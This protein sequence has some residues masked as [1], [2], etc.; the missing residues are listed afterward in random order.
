[1]PPAAVSAATREGPEPVSEGHVPLALYRFT[2]SLSSSDTP[3]LQA[4]KVYVIRVRPQVRFE[5]EFAFIFI[6]SFELN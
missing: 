4:S 5:P 1:M 2:T 3:P 6:L